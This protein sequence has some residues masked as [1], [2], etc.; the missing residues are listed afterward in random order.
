MGFGQKN[1]KNHNIWEIVGFIEASLPRKLT[2]L[3]INGELYKK[4]SEIAEDKELTS[5]QVS[6][7]IKDLKRKKLI[8]CLNEESSKGRL[9]I[10]TDLGKEA[11][12]NLKK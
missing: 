2:I 7:A 1:D 3:S 8:I 12:K 6:N 9:Y 10:L 4:P 5:S 11:V